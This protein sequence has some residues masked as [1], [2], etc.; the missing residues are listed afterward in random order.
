MTVPETIGALVPPRSFD[1]SPRWHVLNCVTSAVEH[2]GDVVIIQ[3]LTKERY[4]FEELPVRFRD[5][6]INENHQ[7]AIKIL[8]VIQVDDLHISGH[9]SHNVAPPSSHRAANRHSPFDYRYGE[10]TTWSRRRRPH[11]SNWTDERRWVPNDLLRES[12]VVVSILDRW[13]STFVNLIKQTV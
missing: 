11:S 6:R 5:N 10:E 12:A 8:S 3:R 7:W 9:V 1:I 4:R 2:C 13:L